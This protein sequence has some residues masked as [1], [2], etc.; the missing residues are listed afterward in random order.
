MELR[1]QVLRFRLLGILQLSCA[2]DSGESN[3]KKKWKVEV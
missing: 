1:V 3:G 2:K